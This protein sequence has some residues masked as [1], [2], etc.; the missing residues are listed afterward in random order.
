M[1]DLPWRACIPGVIP[2]IRKACRVNPR[3]NQSLQ[4][5]DWKPVPSGETLPFVMVKSN[6]R[7]LADTKPATNNETP[8]IRDNIAVPQETSFNGGGDQTT[9]TGMTGREPGQRPL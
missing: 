5:R 2:L 1:S 7:R 8:R 6:A 3:E 9:D 4:V